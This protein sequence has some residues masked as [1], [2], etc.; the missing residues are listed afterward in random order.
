MRAKSSNNEQSFIICILFYVTKQNIYNICI[1]GTRICDLNRSSDRDRDT[2][3][4]KKKHA[5]SLR[6]K[7]RKA[8][9]KEHLEN[10]S[11]V[12]GIY[13]SS[14]G[15]ACRVERQSVLRTKATSKTDSPNTICIHTPP[16]CSFV[17]VYVYIIVYSYA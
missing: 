13:T 17:Y 16:F 8:G 7:R 11:P 14:T 3:D 15:C 9:T 2:S 6:E 4:V 10:H 12:R 1:R 5:D